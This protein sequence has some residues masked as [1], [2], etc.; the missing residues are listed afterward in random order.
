MTLTGPG[1][2]SVLVITTQPSATAASGSAFSQ[3]P[4]IEVQDAFGNPLNTDN[5]RT[6]TVTVSVGGTLVGTTSIATSGGVATFTDLGI[7][8]RIDSA[9]NPYTL[10]F[11]ATGLSSANSNAVELTSA[12]TATQL[13]IM[14]QPSATASS[15]SAVAQQPVIEVQDAYGNPLSLSLI[16]I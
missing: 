16:H 9:N 12:G 7:G 4:V 8:G 6:V 10:T 15:G 11:T 5:G 14:T 3:Q 2:A 1:E 13:V